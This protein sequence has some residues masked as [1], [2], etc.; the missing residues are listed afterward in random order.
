MAVNKSPRRLSS[1]QKANRAI[2]QKLEHLDWPRWYRKLLQIG[3]QQ[4]T[5][6]Y[7]KHDQA[8]QWTV[9]NG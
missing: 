4:T 9:I 8:I 6:C 2:F 5:H 3:L 7:T 1:A